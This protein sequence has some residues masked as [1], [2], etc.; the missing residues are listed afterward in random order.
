MFGRAFSPI[1]EPIIAAFEA[2]SSAIIWGLIIYG[3]IQMAQIGVIATRA[4]YSL[5]VIKQV[6]VLLKEIIK[7]VAEMRRDIRDS[8]K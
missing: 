8:G 1:T 7:D 5:K 6:S 4:Y 2:L 3:V